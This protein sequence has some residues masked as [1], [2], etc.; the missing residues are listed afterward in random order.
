MSYQQTINGFLFNTDKKMIDLQYV[1]D[2][3]ST[4]SYWSQG[5]PYERFFTAFTNSL[6]Y[7]VYRNN[8]QIGFA[9]VVTDY[10]E[11]GL[12]WDVFIDPEYQRQGIGKLLMNSILTNPETKYVFNWFLMT[13]DAHEFYKQFGFTSDPHP[14]VMTKITPRT[15]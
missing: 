14:F 7:G 11:C 8:K 15:F 4:K 5:L 9:R 6:C 12:I 3:L 10:S 13:E 2:F 1:Y